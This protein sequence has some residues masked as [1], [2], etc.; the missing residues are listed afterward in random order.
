M[1]DKKELEII[2]QL[3]DQLQDEMSF[4][5]D[6]FA[7]RLGREEPGIKVIKVST[8]SP[9]EESPELEKAEEELGMD[10]DDDEEMGEDPEHVEKVMGEMGPEESLKKRLMKLRAK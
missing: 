9:M 6:D 4:S 5:K 3:M 1:H 8:E 2:A 7:K 10:L